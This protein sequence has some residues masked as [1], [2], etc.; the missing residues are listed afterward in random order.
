MPDAQKDSRPATVNAQ[1]IAGAS[2]DMRR[3][4]KDWTKSTKNEKNTTNGRLSATIPTIIDKT[5]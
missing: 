1:K 5:E 4:E 2:T 3:G